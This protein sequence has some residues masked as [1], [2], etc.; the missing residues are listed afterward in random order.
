MKKLLLATTNQGKI[1]EYR[2]IFEKLN[3]AVELLTLQDLNIK[4]DLEET[5]ETFKENAIAKAK[6]YYNLS[7]LPTLSDDAGLEIDYLNGEPGVHSRRW[8][9]YTASDEELMNI[10]LEKLKGVP[11]E[12]RGAQLRAIVGLCFSEDE[13]VCTFEGILKGNIAEK[14]TGRVIPGYPFRSIFISENS[15]KHLGELGIIAHR[16]QAIEKALPIIKKHLC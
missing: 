13:N 2:A 4:A 15:N 12:K 9:G 16:W 8:P 6:F 7:K 1:A 14:P 3:I 10:A 11:E 5:G